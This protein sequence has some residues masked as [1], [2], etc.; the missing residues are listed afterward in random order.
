[1]NIMV[2]ES[3]NARITSTT[4][5]KVMKEME[6]VMH[7]PNYIGK[8]NVNYFIV[9]SNDTGE[10]AMLWSCETDKTFRCILDRFGKLGAKV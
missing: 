1:M 4:S 7:D 6:A 2:M 5:G 3:R 9:Y 10:F 8:E